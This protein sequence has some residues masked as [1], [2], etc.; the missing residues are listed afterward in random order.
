MGSYKIIPPGTPLPDGHPFKGTRLIFGM[1]PPVAPK[2]KTEEPKSEKPEEAKPKES[3][4]QSN[5]DDP[6][7]G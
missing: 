6:R 5:Q 1:R 4:A 2:K 7:A 3:P